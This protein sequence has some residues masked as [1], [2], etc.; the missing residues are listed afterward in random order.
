ML[1]LSQNVCTTFLYQKE[2][3]QKPDKFENH[4]GDGTVS[5][6]YLVVVNFISHLHRLN[7]IK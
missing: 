5:Q 2:E 7:L 3:I 6:T 1:M 4:S